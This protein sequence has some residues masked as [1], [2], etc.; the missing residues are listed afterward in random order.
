MQDSKQT[1]GWF[2]QVRLQL[3]AWCLGRAGLSIRTVD[4]AHVDLPMPSP[5]NPREAAEHVC[6]LTG[7]LGDFQGISYMYRGLVVDGDLL[8]KPRPKTYSKSVLFY[9]LFY[10]S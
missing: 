10:F 5:S 9:G 8:P 6:A 2:T 7:N 4:V 3:S 1:A